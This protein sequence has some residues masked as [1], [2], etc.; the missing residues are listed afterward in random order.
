MDELKY[1]LAEGL[2]GKM[3]GGRSTMDSFSYAMKENV[4]KKMNK[5]SSRSKS[6]GTTLGASS[7]NDD[8]VPE[9]GSA[10]KFETHGGGEPAWYKALKKNIK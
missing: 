2:K 10:V 1:R 9:R 7:M 5:Q 3:A 8:L 6:P 4:S